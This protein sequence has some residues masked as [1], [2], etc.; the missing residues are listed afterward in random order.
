[1]E[2]ICSKC[3][4][5]WDA[6]WQF[7]YVDRQKYCLACEH[8]LPDNKKEQGEFK[9]MK[10]PK[11]APEPEP[12]PEPAPDPLTCPCNNKTYKT[13]ASLKAHRKTKGHKVWEEK[14][15]NKEV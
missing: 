8:E 1:M 2:W 9:R 5:I 4:W 3:G 7:F 11:P 14:T 15:K 13:M 12:E 6:V 10:Q